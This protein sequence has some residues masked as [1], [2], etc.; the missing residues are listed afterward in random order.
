[1]QMVTL[2]LLQLLLLGSELGLG[3]KALL[4]FDGGGEHRHFQNDGEKQDR[5]AV[6]PED[7]VQEPEQVAQDA[8]EK[9]KDTQ[10]MCSPLQFG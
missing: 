2:A 3:G 5:D 10:K 7:G 1:M 8:T 4:L 6:V 9:I